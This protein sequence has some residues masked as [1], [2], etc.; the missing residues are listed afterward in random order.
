M[1]TSAPSLTEVV[2]E[3]VAARTG[4]RVKNLAVEVADGRAILRGVTR[5]YHVKQLALHA[6]QEALPSARIENSIVVE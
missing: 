4:R 2:A 1:S 3:R 5:T 6:A